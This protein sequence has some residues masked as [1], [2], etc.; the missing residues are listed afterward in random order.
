MTS[1][2]QLISGR[3][4]TENLVKKYIQSAS[5]SREC[6]IPLA[7]GKYNRSAR[8]INNALNILTA[9]NT[10]LFFE[11]EPDREEA[12]TAS[13]ARPVAPASW[14]VKDKINAELNLETNKE[15]G[16]SDESR[17]PKLIQASGDA[18]AVI[19]QAAETSDGRR[20]R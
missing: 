17:T 1:C 2:P 18:P 13:I 6:H 16:T 20:A 12:S 4:I 19:V 15:T 7:P 5:L 11:C 8:T 9:L 14:Q 10:L 3:P